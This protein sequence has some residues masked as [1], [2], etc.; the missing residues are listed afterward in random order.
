MSG[1]TTSKFARSL[2]RR[3]RCLAR[4]LDDLLVLEPYVTSVP[5]D[6]DL[7]LWPV[8]LASLEVPSD[9]NV[10]FTSLRSLTWRKP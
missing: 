7:L 3:T 8:G 2:S 1:V 5:V 6:F 9:R 4:S 10:S